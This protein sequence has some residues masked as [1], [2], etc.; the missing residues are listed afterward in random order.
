MTRSDSEMSFETWLQQRR[1]FQ[2]HGN[3]A[4]LV[5]GG[6]GHLLLSQAEEDAIAAHLIGRVL[7]GILRRHPAGEVMLITGAAPG[8][9]WIFLRTAASWCQRM[10]IRYR[11]VALL[12]VPPEWLVHDWAA[13]AQVGDTPVP[14][15]D[16]QRCRQELDDLLTES[17]QRVRLYPEENDEI[18]QSTE[19]RID[20]YRRLA[21]CLA[22]QSDVL[23]AML[24]AQNLHRAGG[25]AEVVAWRRQIARIPPALSTLTR[26]Q[27]NDSSQRWPLIVID[28]SV[29]FEIDGADDRQAVAVRPNEHHVLKAAEDALHRGNDLLCH[30]LLAR[31]AKEGF[32]STRGDYLRILT[33]ANIGNTKLALEQYKSMV[34]AAYELDEDWLALHGRL[35]KDLALASASADEATRHFKQSAEA[36]SAA[37]GIWHGPYSGVN[38]ATMHTMAGDLGAARRI[39]EQTLSALQRQVPDSDTAR[40]FQHATT[41]EIALNLGDIDRCRRSMTDADLWLPHDVVRRGRSLAQMGRLCDRLGIGRDVLSAL[42]MPQLFL[43]LRDRTDETVPQPADVEVVLD[44]GI[45]PGSLAYA[46]LTDPVDLAIAERLLDGGVRFYAVVDLPVKSIA[47]TWRERWGSEIGERLKRVLEQAQRVAVVPGFL[48]HEAAWCCSEVQATALGASR[49]TAKRLGCHW[50]Q[51]VVRR[52]NDRYVLDAVADIERESA[53]GDATP[54]VNRRMVG[55]LFADFAGFRRIHDSEMSGFWREIMVPMLSRLHHYGERVLFNATWG[56]ALHVIT[57]DAA[58]AADIAADIQQAVEAARRQQGGTLSRLELRV[59]AHYAPAFIERDPMRER[60]VYYGSQVSFAARIEPVTPPGSVFG[61]D[62]FA[63]RLML[64]APERFQTHYAGELELAKQHG[65]HPLFV[66]HRRSPP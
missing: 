18:A 48:E 63:A 20:Q 60:P 66:I 37:F 4:V 14:D 55:M 2:R 39:A 24:R 51:V 22:E 41:A 10:G 6:T 43:V 40:F 44:H 3:K 15:E 57:R 7:P 58:T 42:R 17:N 11:S 61:S 29:P 32:V 1:H 34:L 53:C 49:M 12:P 21:A 46:A 47:E 26:E 62:T 50:E 30:D 54:D 33:L 59:A 35:E 16:R 25:T 52:T 31:L 9:D 27:S 23:V 8:A 28:P 56:D 36:Y 13:R 65:I 64:E 5:L 45:T 38:A 19:W